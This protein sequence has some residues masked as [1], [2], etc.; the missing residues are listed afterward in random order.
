MLY[1]KNI[2]NN[3]TDLKKKMKKKLNGIKMEKYEKEN[4]K[5]WKKNKKW[6]KVQKSNSGLKVPYI[7]R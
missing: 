6:K 4:K 7:D 3:K 1:E 2:R 5:P